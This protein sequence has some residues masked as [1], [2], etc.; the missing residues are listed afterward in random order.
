MKTIALILVV[1][2]ALVFV[3]LYRAVTRVRARRLAARPAVSLG[4]FIGRI[5]DKGAEIPLSAQIVRSAV[6]KSL[7]ITPD[8]VYPDDRFQAEYH[9]SDSWM[10]DSDEMIFKEINSQLAQQAKPP[11][12]PKESSRSITSV[13]ELTVALARHLSAERPLYSNPPG[14]QQPP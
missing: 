3:G 2:V 11:W 10:D 4:E 6:A 7:G 8:H 14:A 13:R 5:A 9:I 1:V 12:E